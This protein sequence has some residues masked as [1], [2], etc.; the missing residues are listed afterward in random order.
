MPRT[1]LRITSPAQLKVGDDFHFA[2]NGAG[3]GGHYTV[4]AKVTKVNRKTV[5]A[6][7]SP[8]SYRPGTNWRVT[9]DDDC[10]A[11]QY[12]ETV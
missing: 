2:C 11:W 7:E 10:C 1:V 5:A 3:R 6:I 4:Y 12:K 8:G 9:I